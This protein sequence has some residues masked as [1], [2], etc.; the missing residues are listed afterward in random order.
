MERNY[1]S[2]YL[3]TVIENEMKYILYSPKKSRFFFPLKCNF[4]RSLFIWYAFP[5]FHDMEAFCYET[6]NEKKWTKK[7]YYF[8][9]IYYKNTHFQLFIAALAGILAC[10]FVIYSEHST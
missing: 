4:F 3:P 2:Y 8:F 5:S 6:F 10:S 1:I 7:V 9:K